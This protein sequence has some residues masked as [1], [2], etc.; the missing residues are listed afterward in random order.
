M[1]PRWCWGSWFG[2]QNC[3]FYTRV[4]QCP[5]LPSFL[6]LSFLPPFLSSFFQPTSV[7]YGSF[8]PWG[9]IRA[10]A[11]GLCYSHSSSGSEPHLWPT[12]QLTATLDPPPTEWG[13]GLNPF[14]MDTSRIHFCCA[15]TGTPSSLFL[16]RP[17]SKYF[18]LFGHD[19]ILATQ[20]C[21]GCAGADIMN[22]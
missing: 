22:I 13:H 4:L 3:W 5:S 11:P 2:Y 17:D 1:V 14:L 7:A 12:P 8:Q 18:R 9:W 19:C 21:R 15:T 16:T 10:S 20:L 6:P